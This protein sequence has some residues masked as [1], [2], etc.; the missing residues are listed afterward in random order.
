MKYPIIIKGKTKKQ[1]TKLNFSGLGLK[2]FPENLFDYPNLTKLVLCNNRIKVI[3]KEILKLKK[4]KVLDLANNEIAVL[5]GAVFRLPK[6][7]T[8]NL[9]GNHIR[10]FPKQ[11]M[12]SSIQKLIVSNN[13][14]EEGE[15]ERLKEKCEVVF[16]SKNQ[17]TSAEAATVAPEVSTKSDVEEIT[18]SKTVSKTVTKGDKKMEKKHSIFISYSHE[19][20]QWLNKVLKNLKPLQRYYDNVDSWSDKKIMASDVWKDEID[21]ALK[22]A[23][24][25]ILLISS[26]FEASDF[27]TND[28]LQPLLD[29]AQADGT[30]IMPLIVRPCA[31]FEECGLSKYQAVNDP[32][33]P[34]SGMTEYEQEMALVDMV[35]TIKEII[36]RPVEPGRKEVPDNYVKGTEASEEAVRGIVK[37]W[38][39]E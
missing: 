38:R 16:T 31:F 15:L 39:P 4:L 19:D 2:E 32:K 7:Q 1:V 11:V 26:D 33:K 28:E 21:K 34:L 10:K 18:V 37:N 9:Y 14:I 13:P 23:T 36:K 17:E 6:L 30:K 12:D 29:K 3:P 22:K 24:I 5:Q 8:L 25:A 27:I 20:N 35:K